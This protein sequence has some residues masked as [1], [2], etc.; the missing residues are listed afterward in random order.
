[1]DARI[2]ADQSKLLPIASLNFVKMAVITV[3]IPV[4]DRVVFPLMDSVDR[5]PTLLQRIGQS[6]VIQQ[7]AVNYHFF[8]LC[9]ICSINNE[10]I[11]EKDL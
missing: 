8:S 2:S 11:G 9:N 5:K 3:L 6:F 4:L 1:M 10:Q 7:F